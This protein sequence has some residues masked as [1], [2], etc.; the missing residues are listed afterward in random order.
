[1]QWHSP[2]KRLHQ[3]VEQDQPSDS[4]SPELLEAVAKEAA[5]ELV[6]AVE[7]RQGWQF[8][9]V[10]TLPDYLRDLYESFGNALDKR[11]LPGMPGTH[12]GHNKVFPAVPRTPFANRVPALLNSPK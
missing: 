1:L 7:R 6:A 2:E 9:L 11:E 3:A 12:R 5:S 10:F 4:A 8:R